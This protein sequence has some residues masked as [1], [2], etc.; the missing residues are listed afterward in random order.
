MLLG[1]SNSD[2]AEWFSQH[3]RNAGF[4]SEADEVNLFIKSGDNDFAICI[5]IFYAQRNGIDIP[6]SFVQ[7]A[8]IAARYWVDDDAI[9]AC[10]AFLAAEPVTV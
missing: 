1:M 2:V 9:E 5:G 4:P 7:R 8:L 6:Q 3:L 10:E